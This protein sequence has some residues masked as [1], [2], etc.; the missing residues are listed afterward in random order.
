M[1]KAAIA[2]GFVDLVLPPKG[3]AGELERL[4]RH[5]QMAESPS[6]G[7]TAPAT[8]N[9]SDN[10]SVQVILGRLR[11]STGAD[12]T[13]YKQ[14]TIQRR[15][16]RRMLL[17]KRENLQDHAKYADGHPSESAGF[18]QGLLIKVTNVLLGPANLESPKKNE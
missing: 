14:S 15:I 8:E 5:P 13:N 2:T 1:P 9:Q 4:G 7:E 18:L 16:V 6:P 10:K 12:F 17:L 11:R 3:I